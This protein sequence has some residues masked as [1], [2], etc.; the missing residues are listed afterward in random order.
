MDN[1]ISIL[2]DFCGIIGFIISL[3]AINKV[4]N[5]KKDMKNNN[6]VNVSGKTKIAGDFVGRDQR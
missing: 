5:I 4:Y 6:K 3:F 2:A 1:A